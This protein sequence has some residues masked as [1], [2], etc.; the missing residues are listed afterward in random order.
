MKIGWLQQI[1]SEKNDKHFGTPVRIKNAHVSIVLDDF[2]LPAEILVG[3]ENYG[4][5]HLKEIIN[6]KQTEIQNP[7]KYSKY[8][9]R[10]LC[11]VF[12]DN[13]KRSNAK[14]IFNTWGRRWINLS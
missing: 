13:E 10:I 8:G 4:I 14:Y 11:S 1:L 5:P 7:C 2:V 6:E 9:P 3:K 12:I